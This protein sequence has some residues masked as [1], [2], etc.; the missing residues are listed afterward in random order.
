MDGENRF[1]KQALSD[2]SFDIASGGA[3]RHL[4]DIGYSVRR[5]HDSLDYPTPFERVRDAVWQHFLD[6]GV[7]RLEAPGE[8]DTMT[9]VTYVKEQGPYGRTTFRRVEDSSVETR[10][11]ISCDFGI[12][13]RNN[14]TEFSRFTDLLS[15][16]DKEYV[17]G[18]PWPNKIVWH[19]KDERFE[20]IMSVYETR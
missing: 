11:Y 14:P 19:N 13:I 9:R 8:S 10:Q 18:L 2:M 20:R 3:I 16:E 1:F 5:I 7:I 12:A 17:D 6:T 4:A 15:P